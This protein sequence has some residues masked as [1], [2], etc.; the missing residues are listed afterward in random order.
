[1]IN[2]L[3]GGMALKTDDSITYITFSEK[4][5]LT[6]IEKM[7]INFFHK[8]NDTYRINIINNHKSIKFFK[9]TNNNKKTNDY[10]SRNVSYA[11]AIAAKGRIELYKTIKSVQKDGGRVLY[12]DTDS[13]FA[14][15]KKS[16]KR[17]R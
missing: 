8:I 7:D 15:Y 10:S 9:K 5:F 6:I 11:S 17:V 16:D 12:C 3:Y 14:C 1:M 13:I 4:E 2:S